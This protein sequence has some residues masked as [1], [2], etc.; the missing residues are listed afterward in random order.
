MKGIFVNC[1]INTDYN[2]NSFILYKQHKRNT[3]ACCLDDFV[4]VM[5]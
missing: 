4:K 5:I 3:D 2:F 1:Y